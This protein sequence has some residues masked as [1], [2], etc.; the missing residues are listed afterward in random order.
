MSTTC[1]RMLEGMDVFF[2][3]LFRMN[4][5]RQ[6]GAILFVGDHVSWPHNELALTLR[7]LVVV[8]T[9]VNGQ[10]RCKE[11]R[12]RNAGTSNVEMLVKKG[13]NWK[14]VFVMLW[15]IL[16]LCVGAG[17]WGCP[18]PERRMK[19]VHTTLSG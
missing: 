1:I 16:E 9:V 6:C 10:E 12:T 11:F 2:C 5:L 15:S 19:E 13:S 8:T 3:M 17:G 18:V 14:G 4:P 7:E